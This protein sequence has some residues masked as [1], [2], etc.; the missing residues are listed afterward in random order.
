MSKYSILCMML[1]LVAGVLHAQPDH[2]GNSN[3][4]PLGPLGASPAE[5]VVADTVGEHHQAATPAI[6]QSSPDHDKYGS[7]EGVQVI[8]ESYSAIVHLE[9]GSQWFRA[10]RLGLPAV[11]LGSR[12]YEVSGELLL[13]LRTAGIRF[14]ITGGSTRITMPVELMTDRMAGAY[15]VSPQ[16]PQDITLDTGQIQLSSGTIDMYIE[17]NSGSAQYYRLRNL[18]AP[19]GAWVTNLSYRLRISDEGNG[20]IYCGDYELWLF[21][22][23]VAYENLVYNNL[24]GATDGGWD[25][26]TAD[27]SDIYL[28]WRQTSYFNGQNPNQWW[29]VIAWDNLS[30]DDGKLDYIEFRVDWESPSSG[31]AYEPDD[32]SAQAWDHPHNYISGLRSID[33]V[34]D[35]DW[36]R[37][38]LSQRS[39]VIIEVLGSTGDTRL[40]L[41]DSSLNEIEFDDDGGSGLFSLINRSGTD[42][43]PTG[44]YYAKVDEYGGNAI[45]SDYGISLSVVAA[46]LPDLTAPSS[47]FTS[48]TP[49]EGD[50]FYVE[51]SITNDGQGIAAASHARLYLSTDNDFDVSDD[52]EVLPEKSVSSLSGGGVDPTRWDFNFPDLLNSSTYSVW[53]VFVVD[54][55]DEVEES[56]ENNIFKSNNPLTVTNQAAAVDLAVGEVHFRDQSGNAGN[57]V[58]NPVPGASLY[59]HFSYSLDASASITGK[60]WA[61]DLDGTPLCSYTSTISNGNWVGWCTSPTTI[62]SGPFTLRGVLDPDS[63]F[64]ESNESNNVASRTY[65]ACLQDGFE[66]DNSAGQSSTLTPGTSQAHSICPIGDSDWMTFTLNTDS[67]IVVETTGASG[68]TRMWLYDSN[69]VQLEYND[70]GVGLF[71]RIDRV[72]GTDHLPAGTYYVE[73]DEYGDNGVIS[74]YDILL[75][76]SGCAADP[77]IRIEPLTLSFSSPGNLDEAASPTLND[78]RVHMRHGVI[79]PALTASIAND[80]GKRQR[81]VLMQFGRM[82]GPDERAA[83]GAAGLRVLTYLPYQ[84]YWV[85]LSE[86]FDRSVADQMVDGISWAWVPPAEYKMAST[87]VQ[88]NFPAYTVYDDGTVAVRILFFEDVSRD[89][90]SAAL[91]GLQGGLA[92][93][94]WVS[95][96]TAMIRT[97]RQ[98]IGELAALDEVE[99]LEPALPAKISHN[100][101]AAARIHVDDIRAAPYN[102]DGQGVVVGIWDGGAVFPHTDFGNRLT[103]VDNVAAANHA[104]HV[105]G[106]VGGSGAGNASAAGM[107]PAVNLRSYDWNS[108]ENEMRLAT[109][110]GIHLSNHSYG[111]VAG[112]WWDGSQWVDTGDAL[113]GQYST[114][115]QE[116]DEIVVDTDLLVF[117]SAGNDRNDC[118]A[119][120]DC[121]GPFD[122]ISTTGVAKNI[123]TVCATDDG[124][125]MSSFSSWGPA[126][127][128]RL[129]PDL[130]ANGT[131]LTSTVPNNLYDSS[132]GTSMSSPSSAGAAALLR[133]HYVNE[134]GSAPAAA[135]LKALMIHGAGDLG[136]TGPDYEHGWGLI[137][138]QR[139]AD[140]ISAESWLSGTIAATGTDATYTMNV[141]SGSPTLKVTL[142]WTDPAG[143][144]AAAIALVNDLDLILT[145]PDN[146]QHRPWILNPANPGAN[147]T[148]GVN[149]RDNVEQVVITNPQAGEWTITVSGFAVPSGPQVF[150]LV[151]EGLSGSAFTIFNDGTGPLNVSSILPE[152]SAQW[153]TITPTSGSVPAGGSMVVNVDVDFQ[154]APEGNH[155]TRIMVHSNDADESPYPS[156]VYVEVNNEGGR[157]FTDRFESGDL[158]AWSTHVP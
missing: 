147:A 9:N 54:S 28:N 130:C 52:Y 39:D 128:G 105:A 2:A 75:T 26:D 153:M 5:E 103:V 46:P 51:A 22:G 78:R 90:A 72:C 34:G 82:P 158:S 6:S 144:P 36:I 133:Q 12:S 85:S 40:W 47:G 43:L 88:D 30:G 107:A 95:P 123:V 92:I 101:T 4:A 21:S 138:S 23:D 65:T 131:T 108:D 126:D 98:W 134:V 86:D 139:S 156:G 42:A 62:P 89:E 33:P 18:I 148:R 56:D 41:Y 11:Q 135:T 125:T 151:G 121:D 25:D 31:D 60:L 115:V 45:I 73:I 110:N 49:T 97:E 141:G 71:S 7:N 91:A 27:D 63:A 152:V 3:N 14:D 142:A 17:D 136:R 55:Q 111:H 129:K 132:S 120:G 69:L 99:W 15:N 64:A 150:T 67:G 61:M 32:S 83:L 96:R 104:T 8:A 155:T 137:N 127:D 116:W 19:A 29:G 50:S 112:W 117:K 74:D 119:P 109:G 16:T 76:A 102:L 100:S 145:A 106:T 79:D 80:L 37:F 87:V 13:A 53:L 24:G 114:T 124:D 113:F 149:R 154:A 38:N 143:S 93:V 59:P 57:V 44:L 58:A 70:D 66:P 94:D 146:T 77:D 140:L 20:A 122:S 68:D 48:W 35:E 1:I 84:T 81:H 157:I 10:R 118:G